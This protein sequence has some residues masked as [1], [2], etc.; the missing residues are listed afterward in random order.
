MKT[1]SPTVGAVVKLKLENSTNAD[2]NFEV[3]MN[4]T[5]AESWETLTFDF[6]AAPAFNY[7]RVVVFFD[8][9][10]SPAG[11]YTSARIKS[12]NLYEF[13]YGRVEVRAKLPAGGGIP[14]EIVGC[15]VCRVC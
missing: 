13:T 2:E 14:V 15:G 7:D 12:E 3:D 9:G 10:V 5:V 11:A 8:F 6:S 4:T 1:W